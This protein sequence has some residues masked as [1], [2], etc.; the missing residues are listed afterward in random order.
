MINGP[1]RP[2]PRTGILVPPLPFTTVTITGEDQ[3]RSERAMH[4]GIRALCFGWTQK[5]E[6]T[7]SY[8]PGTPVWMIDRALAEGPVTRSLTIAAWIDDPDDRLPGYPQIP[9][10]TFTWNEGETLGE[11]L[12]RTRQEHQEV[13]GPGGIWETRPQ[14]GVDVFMHT[15]EWMARFVLAG[16]AWLGQKV[17]V[18]SR[19]HIERHARKRYNRALG[20]SVDHVRVISLRRVDRD[21]EPSGEGREFSCR[22][23]VDGHFRNQACGVGFGERR[24][25][26]VHPYVKGPADKEL[27][28]PQRKVYV[29]NR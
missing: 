13:Y 12:V 17:L 22:W 25:V 20:N 7:K 2:L 19:G 29:V 23:T 5:H 18:E 24:L 27:R 14:V 28:V 16:M 1:C 21:S 10:Q 9:S 3:E 4:T 15:A 11:M 26:Y 8:P 6:R